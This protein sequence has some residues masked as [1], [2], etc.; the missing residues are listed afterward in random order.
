MLAVLLGAAA[1]VAVATRGGPGP[2]PQPPASGQ[3]W[4]L[5]GKGFN[6]PAVQT[7]VRSC[8][9]PTPGSLANVMCDDEGFELDLDST[10]TVT[11]VVLYREEG[12]G[13]F[14]Q[15]TGTM[16]SGLAWSDSYEDVV[17]KLGQPVA[18]DGGWGAVEVESTFSAS[19]NTL[20]V[21]WDTFH[22]T[23]AD[24]AAAH[25]HSISIKAE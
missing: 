14:R 15:Y 25:M 10:L 12:G 8:K 6:D 23:D 2:T 24:L 5:L 9:T 17:G 18:V 13:G 19:P 1:V 4:D 7:W 21:T 22:R 3:V 20:Q 16:P 11:Q